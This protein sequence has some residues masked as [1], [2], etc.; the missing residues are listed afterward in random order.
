MKGMGFSRYGGPEVLEMVELAD[1][2][3]GAKEVVVRTIATSMN[4]VDILVR[5]GYHGLK[6]DMPHLP[7]TDVVGRVERLGSDVKGLYEGELVTANTVYG[8]SKCDACRAGDDQLCSEWKMVGLHT[9]G[10][11]GELVKLPASIIYRPP[12]GFSENELAA[13]PLDLS[14]SWRII[15]S[16]GGRRAGD[17]VVIRGASGNLGIFATMVAKA[18]GMKVI[19]LSRDEN[20]RERLRGL[21]ADL[22]ID[23]NRSAGEIRKEV[24]DFSD[25]RG[26]DMVVESFGATLDESIGL[27]RHGGKVVVF[28]T[29]AG[30]RSDVSIPPLYLGS[31]SVLGIHNASLRELRDSFEFASKNNIRPV[32]A[33]VMGMEEAREAHAML[34]E[35]RMFGKI[36]LRHGVNA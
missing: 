31:V 19:C 7:G 36:V 23:A 1:P 10:A 3:P 34:Q 32:I 27:L 26:A 13:M 18:A 2:V 24:M 17:M 5:L 21:G 4:R 22:A 20:K 8:C 16:I 33:R 30:T 6:L 11:Y 15:N 35:S 28:G 9:N 14:L 12:K 25:G 29:I